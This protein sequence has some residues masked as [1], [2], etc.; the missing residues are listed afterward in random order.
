MFVDFPNNTKTGVK[1]FYPPTSC[2]CWDLMHADLPNLNLAIHCED[3]E[4][5]NDE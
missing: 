2:Y 5:Q 4:T 1:T 3:G